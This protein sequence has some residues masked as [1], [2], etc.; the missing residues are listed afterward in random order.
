MTERKPPPLRLLI[1]LSV[2]LCLMAGTTMV[3]ILANNTEQDDLRDRLDAVERD[4]VRG[5]QGLHD[6]DARMAGRRAGDAEAVR[7]ELAGVVERVDDLEDRWKRLL[8]K[9]EDAS[10]ATTK[11]SSRTTFYS[12]GSGAFNVVYIIERTLPSVSERRFECMRQELQESI[13]HL[14]DY[15]DFHIIFFGG[16][17]LLEGPGDDVIPA[18]A[19]NRSAG[20]AFAGAVGPVGQEAL[21][22]PAL[23]R[24]FDVLRALGPKRPNKVIY[25]L[26]ASPI[27]DAE[28]VLELLSQNETLDDLTINSINTFVF[29]P[30]DPA[31]QETLKEIAKQAHGRFRHVSMEDMAE[32]LEQDRP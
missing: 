17:T 9:P 7:Q 26:A 20:I 4:M 19:P 5:L 32:L 29:G 14:K 12:S 15:N 23:T 25:I 21:L 8:V 10:K 18:T 30:K 6:R 16:P 31:S 13:S 22:A 27:T 24:A 3:L 11:P 1:A 2:L 28:E